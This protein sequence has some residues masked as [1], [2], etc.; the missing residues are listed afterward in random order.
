MW[1]E[2]DFPINESSIPSLKEWW[3]AGLD[4]LSRCFPIF[5]ILHLNTFQS[6]PP[7]ILSFDPDSKS[8]KLSSHFYKFKNGKVNDRSK[9]TLLFS[10]EAGVKTSVTS[11]LEQSCQ[12]LPDSENKEIKKNSTLYW[13]LTVLSILHTLSLNNHN[14]FVKST[15]WLIC[16]I[17]SIWS[18]KNK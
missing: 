8:W 12:M 7:S 9:V 5:N 4:N 17:W 18:L 3:K 11:S 16:F 15:L 10:D 2:S 6:T 13:V 1:L 14:H